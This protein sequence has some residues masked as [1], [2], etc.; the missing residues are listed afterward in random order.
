MC[1]S[2]DSTPDQF[3]AGILT[4]LLHRIEVVN[5]DAAVSPRPGRHTF[6]VS[7][8]WTDG[9][10]IRLV[11]TAPPSDR[12]WGMA[13]DTRESLINPSAW[14]D[15]DNPALY[16]YLLDLEESWPGESSSQPGDDRD[17]I[18]WC[19]DPLPDLH[20]RASE[21]PDAYW[22]TSPPQDPSWIDHTPPVHIEP[23]RC[24][25]PD[26][27]LPRGADGPAD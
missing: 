3:A 7:H 11:Y 2:T 14:N 22:Y 6:L 5:A 25:D 15:A 10:S 8:A 4:E 1:P 23:R 17:L 12:I 9:A 19:G 13:R 18:Q 21:L 27:P 20:Q 16:Y 26:G 24:A